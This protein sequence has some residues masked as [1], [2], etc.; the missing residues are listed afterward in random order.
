MELEAKIHQEAGV[1]FNVASPKQLGEILFG[2]LNLPPP[3]KLKTG[4][5]PTNSDV[6]EDL[7]AHGIPLAQIILDWRQLAKL[8]GTYTDA[9]VEKINPQTKRIHTSFSQTIT[10][11]GRLASSDPNL[12]NIPVRSEEGRKIRRAFIVPQ[13]SKLVSFDYSQI[14]LRILA[15]MAGVE[16]LKT[17]FEQGRDIHVQTASRMFGIGAE[18]VNSDLRRQAKAI[19]FGIIYGM[20]AFGLSQSLKI[21]QAQAK[22]YI[23]VYFKEFPEIERYMEDTK[24]F[25]SKN[26]YV[27]TLNNRKCAIPG[28]QDKNGN[29]RAFAQR[30]AINAPIQGTSADMI[31]ESM[32]AIQGLLKKENYKTKMILQ[33]HDELLFEVPDDEVDIVV[34]QIQ[35]LMEETHLFIPTPVNYRVGDNWA[36]IHD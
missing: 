7:V 14:E 18:D 4:Q 26:G 17:Y 13:G 9:L 6:L 1:I 28:I 31:K 12:Q 21:P 34:P 22:E 10:S 2:R 3:K 32:I 33:V 11:T 27:L 20:S 36:Q 24:E 19:N 16:A 15:D 35:K 25:A 30:Q 8:K 23:Q 29:I 5:Y